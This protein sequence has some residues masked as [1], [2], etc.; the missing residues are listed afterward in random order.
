[1]QTE[2]P[3]DLLLDSQGTSLPETTDHSL[4][5]DV[6]LSHTSPSLGFRVPHAR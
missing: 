4:A 6:T 3:L 2:D 5:S 1:M